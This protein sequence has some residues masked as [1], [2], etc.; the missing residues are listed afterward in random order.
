MRNERARI[1]KKKE[2]KNSKLWS[3]RKTNRQASKK[4][5]LRRRSPRP[6]D[7]ESVG[8]IAVPGPPPAANRPR[9]SS[10]GRRSGKRRRS[11]P[12]LPVAFAFPFPFR[13]RRRLLFGQRRDFF[14]GERDPLG[15]RRR[16]LMM[17]AV[18][19]VSDRSS[20][21]G[22]RS[23]ER[24]A[25]RES[26]RERRQ[27]CCCCRCCCHRCSCSRKLRLQVPAATKGGFVRS[28]VTGGRRRGDDRE[29]GRSR[30]RLRPRRRV[31][32]RP[33]RRRRRHQQPPV[34]GLALLPDELVQRVGPVADVLD[35][36]DQKR[37]LRG[38]GERVGVPPEF[39]WFVGWFFL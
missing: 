28:E 19:V 3:G 9:S 36:D 2:R 23:G 10:R 6:V 7:A 1:E 33:R 4:T 38:G 8:N 39:G 18:A 24:A 14:F 29:G 12:L 21:D 22:E 25:S 32:W 34:P 17:V 35:D 13:R 26:R 11:G 15:Q 31:C 20:D 27:T 16:V 5:N 37:V 30:R